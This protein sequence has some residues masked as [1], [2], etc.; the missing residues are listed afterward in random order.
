[1]KTQTKAKQTPQV[2]IGQTWTPVVTLEKATADFAAA[3]KS[4]PDQNSYIGD[5]IALT[6]RMLSMNVG[7]FTVNDF[8]NHNGARI[9]PE[10]L[11]KLATEYCDYM[12]AKGR[13][14]AIDGCYSDIVYVRL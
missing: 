3:R 8:F 7:S 13:L 14:T 2:A 10:V 6:S 5:F 11:R 4:K 12:V 9:P 1:M